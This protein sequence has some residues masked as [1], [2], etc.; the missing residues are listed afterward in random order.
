MILRFPRR[1]RIESALSG[2]CSV[3]VWT[4]MRF[5]QVRYCHTRKMAED[6]VINQRHA[7]DVYD[8]PTRS[9]YD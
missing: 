8:L 6:F 5:I 4:G 3:M 2:G 1:Y 7:G 9:F